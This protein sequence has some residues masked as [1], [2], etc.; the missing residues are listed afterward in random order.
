MYGWDLKKGMEIANLFEPADPS[1]V[2]YCGEQYPRGSHCQIAA[3]NHLGKPNFPQHEPFWK[4]YRK[5]MH[6]FSWFNSDKPVRTHGTGALR[7]QPLIY[8]EKATAWADN[9]HF[10]NGTVRPSGNNKHCEVWYE[11]K[12]PYYISYLFLEGYVKGGGSDYVGI[13]ISA[14]GGKTLTTLSANIMK[15]FRIRN[16]L[17]EKKSG[18]ASVQ[19]TKSFLIRIDMHSHSSETTPLLESLRITA[20]YQQNMFTQPFILPGK[21]NL[22]IEGKELDGCKIT[23]EWN[24]SLKG[25]DSTTSFVLS[26]EGKVE[27]EVDLGF[28]QPDEIIMRGVAI[29]CE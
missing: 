9:A 27:Q 16:G 21:N 3:Y 20:G 5:N 13:S 2:L 8:G 19:Y 18:K 11:I 6:D 4:N 23:A 22:W 14:D 15:S 24:Y 26:K 28:R 7:W 1:L 10:E 25:V 29:R 17:E 12:V